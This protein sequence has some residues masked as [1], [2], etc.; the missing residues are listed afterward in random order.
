MVDKGLKG[1][2]A[3]Q[4]STPLEPSQCQAKEGGELRLSARVEAYPSVGVMWY[5][6]G[7]NSIEF[8]YETWSKLHKMGF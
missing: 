1:Y 2:I 4:F 7:V 6:D 3:P 8:H 5:K